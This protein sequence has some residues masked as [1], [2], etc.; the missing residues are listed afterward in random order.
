MK[1]DYLRLLE[2]AR[3]L[4]GWDS[5]AEVS[6]GLSESGMSVSEQTLTNWKTRGISAQGILEACSIIGARTNFIMSSDLPIQDKG[7]ADQF[8]VIASRCAEL[9]DKMPDAEQR[10]LLNYLQVDAEQNIRKS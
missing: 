5:P 8:G 2:A 7:R 9:I 10:R 3:V 1:L 6:R 4:R